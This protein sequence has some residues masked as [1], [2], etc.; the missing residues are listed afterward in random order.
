MPKAHFVTV[1]N[2]SLNSKSGFQHDRLLL[3]IRLAWNGTLVMP[4]V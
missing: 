3:G 1:A 2:I 4:K